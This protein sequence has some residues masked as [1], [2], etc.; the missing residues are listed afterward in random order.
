MIG[1]NICNG[2]LS[3][4][5]TLTAGVLLI[6]GA[7]ATIA[8]L[9]LAYQG[10][11]PAP[12]GDFA[13][14]I[15]GLAAFSGVILIAA[16]TRRQ[17]HVAAE[18]P[19]ETS[20]GPAAQAPTELVDQRVII[21]RTDDDV[22]VCVSNDILSR[23]LLIVGKP[24]NGRNAPLEPII[25]S[26]MRDDR[27][28][29]N[30]GA[31]V[32]V[33]ASDLL[34]ERLRRV[35]EREGS[36]QV[37]FIDLSRPDE[38]PPLNPLDTAM[39]S[40]RDASVDAVIR[41][42]KSASDFWGP[43]LE[44][45][46]ANNLKAMYEYNN[47]EDTPRSEML[48][49]ADLPKM[50]EDGPIAKTGQGEHRA[51]RTPF[52]CRVLDRVESRE[53]T[54]A[55]YR[56]RGWPPKTRAEAIAPLLSLLAPA[57]RSAAFRAVFGQPKSGLAM[58]D[59]LRN[60]R[61]LIVSAE[62]VQNRK[63]LNTLFYTIVVTALEHALRRQ[64]GFPVT[65]RKQCL[66]VADE[67][68]LM[69]AV[70]WEGMLRESRKHGGAVALSTPSLREYQT[71]TRQSAEGI[72]NNCGSILAYQLGAADAQLMHQELGYE[73]SPATLMEIEPESCYARLR[74]TTGTVATFK[75]RNLP[76]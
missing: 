63:L 12:Y 62:G 28:G 54:T 74:A 7:L 76:V 42:L 46:A 8:T 53:V 11:V 56:L 3:P 43:R 49:V 57:T 40:D 29:A 39:Y 35:A 34:P 67:F 64:E 60:E 37:K 36:S 14:T 68:E 48:N 59:V 50:L 5:K 75:M 58:Q 61:T 17:P 70:D 20:D 15:A 38:T 41:A 72:A 24:G 51:D 10:A 9:N 31:T 55:L 69:D 22:P 1:R 16:S 19:D 52:Q 71:A 6:A 13:G 30:R 26:R 21:G 66:L 45:I 47:H 65:E 25:A 23:H 32:V 73:I 44:D 27:E 18:A 2:N 4:R 33:G